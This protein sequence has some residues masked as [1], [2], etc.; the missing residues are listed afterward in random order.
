MG[1]LLMS[2]TGRRGHLSLPQSLQFQ[3]QLFGKKAQFDTVAMIYKKCP[4]SD[5][6]AS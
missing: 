3:R 2:A 4:V 5:R 1:Q 6:Q